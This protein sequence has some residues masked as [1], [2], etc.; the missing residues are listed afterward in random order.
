MSI[1]LTIREL[2]PEGFSLLQV[3]C[4]LSVL[5][6]Y[7]S[8]LLRILVGFRVGQRLFEL[9]FAGCKA[10]H[11]GFDLPKATLAL[12]GPRPVLCAGPLRL[13]PDP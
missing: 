11:L 8:R 13:L 5:P 10:L 6:G 1:L 9:G 2:E 7:F 4:Y 3:F 12:A